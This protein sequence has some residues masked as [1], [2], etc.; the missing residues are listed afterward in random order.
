MNNKDPFP[1]LLTTPRHELHMYVLNHV[2]VDSF[3]WKAGEYLPVV[4]FF[5][6]YFELLLENSVRHDEPEKEWITIC[7]V[8]SVVVH[9]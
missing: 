3:R 8:Y 4:I 6:K 9:S 2:Y 7:A 5:E 1:Y